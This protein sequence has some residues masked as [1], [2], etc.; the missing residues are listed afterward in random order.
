MQTARNFE[1]AE[2]PSQNCARKRAK[3]ARN[4]EFKLKEKYTLLQQ[5]STQKNNDRGEKFE[6]EL[7]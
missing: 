7:P 5:A 4:L 2:S 6:E 1:K 3:H